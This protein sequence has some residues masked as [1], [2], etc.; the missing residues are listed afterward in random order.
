MLEAAAPRDLREVA[1][2]AVRIE[3]YIA[4]ERARKKDRRANTLLLVEATSAEAA[5]RVVEPVL[6]ELATRYRLAE[7]V[8]HPGGG[9]VLEYLARLD[10][11]AAQGALLDRIREHTGDAVRAAEVRSLKGLKKRPG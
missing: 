8:P 3:R 10:G 1:D 6:E 5:Q 9:V 7:I 4:E 2:R 11:E